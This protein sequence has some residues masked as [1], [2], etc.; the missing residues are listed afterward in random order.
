VKPKDT[1]AAGNQRRME[2]L[3]TVCAMRE[4]DLKRVCRLGL[5]LTIFFLVGWVV[6]GNFLPALAQ[7]LPSEERMVGRGASCELDEQ[8]FIVKGKNK[9][10]LRVHR[11]F[12][13]YNQRGKEYGRVGQNLNKFV[14]I[15]NIKAQLMDSDG[16]L[17]KKLNKSDIIEESPFA[18]YTLYTDSRL[19][20]FY[21]SAE[22]YP[23]TLE[24]SYEVRY[25]SL[26][27]WPEWV[28]QMDIPVER[29]VYTLILPKDLAFRMCKRNLEI[30][31]IEKQSKG[32]RE[33]VF[34]LAEVP[35]FEAEKN[36]PPETDHRMS[37]LFAPDQ[38]D[39]AGYPGSTNSWKAFGK[40]YASLAR[41]QYELSRQP[42]S[43]IA[44]VVKN[45]ASTEEKVRALYQ[46]LQRKTRYVSMDLG[47]GGWKPRRA[48]SVLATGYGDCKDLTTLFIAMLNAIG[49]QA[50]P[51]LIQTRDEG[52]VLTDFPSNQFNHVITCVP[53]ERDT[54]WL[55]CT[56]NYCSFGELPWQ[57]EGCQALVIMKDTAALV[58]TPV[59]SAEENRLTWSIHARL[60]PDGSLEITG[61]LTATS[62]YKSSYRQLL[63]SLTTDEK[64]EWLRRRISRYAPNYILLSN[65]FEKIPDLDVSFGIG[66][67]AKLIDYPTTAG[68]DLLINLNL[69]S[70]VA[71]EDI[72]REKEREYPVDNRFA[73]TQEDEIT[74]DLPEDFEIEAVPDGQDMVFPFGSFQTHYQVDKSQLS[75]RR[76]HKIT[77]RLIQPEDFEEY[78]A[79]VDGLYAA[80][81]LFVVL[82]KNR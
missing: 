13:I 25:K 57:D 67:T 33:L 23:Y 6:C 47:I 39:L 4:T 69:L 31:P 11:I 76:V 3:N 65:D 32:K 28:P 41:K 1:N 19:K 54:L 22:K 58:K 82:R 26:F 14:E 16:G 51:A 70:R 64:T 48:E 36:M 49:I 81:Q 78:K 37:V 44:D 35:S 60:E 63:N 59:G 52:T 17:I 61:T 80:D 79:F 38:F 56:C 15:G 29:S 71:A 5:C 42:C 24:Y 46:F 18:V 66:F 50:Y 30:E 75:Y 20:H 45:C 7:S 72:L 73:F 62:N 40:W 68:N 53:L 77:Q 8:K 2:K 10:V 55:D 27:F 43:M 74:L 9:A 12:H 21:L 34:E